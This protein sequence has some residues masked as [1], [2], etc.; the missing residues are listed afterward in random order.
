MVGGCGCGMYWSRGG[1]EG[2]ASAR[3]AARLAVLL[4]LVATCCCRYCVQRLL[5]RL[6]AGC[7]DERPL[8]HSALVGAHQRQTSQL[9]AF[10]LLLDHQDD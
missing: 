3:R 1:H 4:Q 10:V 8:T 5:Q 9:G 2:G 6:Q 7:A